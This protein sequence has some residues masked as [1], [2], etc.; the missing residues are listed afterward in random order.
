M[1][2]CKPRHCTSRGP[3][4]PICRALQLAKAFVS[5][6]RRNIM[7]CKPLLLARTAATTNCQTSDLRSRRSALVAFGLGF[8]FVHA[9]TGCG[10]G[11]N[12]QGGPLETYVALPAV[13]SASEDAWQGRYIGTVTIGDVQYFGDALLTADGLIRL[14]VG[15]PGGDDGQTIQYVVPAGSA[16]LVGSLQGQKNQISGDGLVFGQECAISEPI[17]F[18]AEVGKANISIAL[19]SSSSPSYVQGEILVTT[20]GGTETWS[21]NLALWTNWYTLSA[22][23]DGLAANYQEELAEFSISG[24]TIISIAGDGSLFF[25]SP[26]S[27]CTG[28]G[29][30]QPHLAG[31][32]YVYDVSLTISGCQ[33]PY[34]Y[35]NG[36]YSGLAS[37]SPSGYWDYD[38]VLRMWLSQDANGSG[39]HAPALTLLGVPE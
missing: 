34:D 1:N 5:S 23:P 22:T 25:Q 29:Q 17:R 39:G 19:V 36:T 37:E 32:V 10:G 14:Y 18:C 8:L 28:N 26:G 7:R 11:G 21:L 12:D 2:H 6:D 13:P 24:D 27:A 33:A 3:M 4:W 30:S 31:A 9:L 35:L 20:S 15:G 16:Q 38:T